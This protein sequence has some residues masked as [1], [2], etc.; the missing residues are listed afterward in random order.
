MDPIVEAYFKEYDTLREEVLQ[1][2][3]HRTQ[4][5]SFWLRG[6]RHL[7]DWHDPRGRPE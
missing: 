1:S 5:I 3:T 7:R 6:Y 2:I 4:I